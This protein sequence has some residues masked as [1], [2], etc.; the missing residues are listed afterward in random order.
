M[1]ISGWWEALIE[2]LKNDQA[3]IFILLGVAYLGYKWVNKIDSTNRED[4]AKLA[5]KVDD[6]KDTVAKS[7]QD[8]LDKWHRYDRAAGTAP[9]P[10]Q[11]KKAAKKKS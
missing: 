10:K 7:L 9:R 3:T 2:S 11:V 6:V 1:D 4:H 8:H 5:Q